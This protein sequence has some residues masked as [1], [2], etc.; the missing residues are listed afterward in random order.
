MSSAVDAA[1]ASGYQR[2]LAPGVLPVYDLSI[3]FLRKDSATKKELAAKESDPNKKAFLELQSQI[4]L[5]EVRWAFAQGKYDLSQPIYRHLLEQSWRKQGSL[6]LL[7]ERVHQMKVLPDLL[8][9]F[10]PTVDLR[11]S[12]SEGKEVEPGVF[13]PVNAT[14][15]PPSIVA[16]A[17][18][19]EE[20]LYTLIMIDPDVPDTATESYSTFIHALQTNIPISAT[21]TQITLSNGD[22]FPYIPPHPQ[23]GTPYH[24]YTTFLLPQSSKLDLDV[25]QLSRENFNMRA[26]FAEHGFSE[27]GGMHMFRQEWDKSVS[28]IYKTILG[29][30]EPKYGRPPKLNTYIDAQGRRPPKYS[31]A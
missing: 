23:N 16:Q 30:P 13:L 6:D 27:G 29:K 14:L 17:F 8:P 19:P 21:K 9:S 5:P 20:K 28:G 25:S 22:V 15:Q 24:R 12:F 2:P 11:V 18:H 4:N 26:F 3:E 1:K 7:M 10:H 31:A